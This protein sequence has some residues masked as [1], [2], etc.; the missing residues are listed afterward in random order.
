MNVNLC[1]GVSHNPTEFSAIWIPITIKILLL[2]STI[3][4]FQMSKL[5]RRRPLSS[6]SAEAC[7]RRPGPSGRNQPPAAESPFHSGFERTHS[8]GRFRCS[9]SRCEKES[10]KSSGTRSGRPCANS[11]TPPQPDPA[12]NILHWPKERTL[13]AHSRKAAQTHPKPPRLG[14]F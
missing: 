13:E 11:R 8:K 10:D 9:D 2:R 14:T 4:V 3:S 1:V 12:R 7:T 5:Q 6:C